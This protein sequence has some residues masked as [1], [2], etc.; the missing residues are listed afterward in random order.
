MKGKELRK[1]E[2]PDSGKVAYLPAVSMAVIAMKLKRKYPKPSPPLQVIDLGDGQKVR[3]YNYAHPDY[4][5][6]V[7]AWNDFVMN[8]AGDIAYERATTFTLTAEQQAETDAWKEANP[9]EWDGKDS[10]KDLWLEEIA[11]TTDADFQALL[12]FIQ[13]A[14]QPA[15]EVVRA[16]ADGFRGDVQA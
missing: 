5:T 16:V 2:F 7:K 3:E 13:T 15:E 11:I 14:G 6:G 4:T 12:E 8:E 10:D 9:N 1:V